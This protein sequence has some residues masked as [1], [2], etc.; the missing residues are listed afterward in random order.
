MAVVR[1]GS[2]KYSSSATATSHQIPLPSGSV[3]GDFVV[4]A[5]VNSSWSANFTFPGTTLLNSG[6]ADG[7][8]HYG[9][10]TKT[11]TSGDITAGSLTVDMSLSQHL[12]AVIVGYS[13]A[14]TVEVSTVWDKNNV[15]LAYTDAPVTAANSTND[16]LVFSLIKHSSTSQAYSSTSPSVTNL[17]TA[18]IQGQVSAFGGVYTGTPA[19]RRNTWGVASANGV[20]F[21]VA[22]KESAGPSDPSTVD[23]DEGDPVALDDAT[24]SGTVNRTDAG[25]Y[26]LLTYPQGADL[27]T[28]TW[29]TASLAAYSVRFYLH[30]PSSWPDTAAAIFHAL[31]GASLLAGVDLAGTFNPGQLRWK[32]SSSTEAFRTTSNVMGASSV[33]RVEIQVDTVNGTIR[34][35]LFET[36]SDA[37]LYDSGVISGSVGGSAD[38][39]SFGRVK[40]MASLLSFSISRVKVVNTVGSLIGR[41]TTDVLPPGP[42]VLGVWNGSSLD[43]VS[44][45]GVWNGTSVDSVEILAIN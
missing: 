38:G 33:Y 2:N 35:A 27:A 26:D 4:V 39:F 7:T 23:W 16:I 31:S 29:P 19:Q 45:L 24:I 13:V 10:F 43:A 42:T 32:L 37:A 14:G 41:H 20:G 34:G 22:V 1:R 15:S 8:M 18:I 9:L 44:I 17:Q 6:V 30:T 25:A 21:Q 11:L 12:S 36:G 40:T 28:V 5:A 3:A